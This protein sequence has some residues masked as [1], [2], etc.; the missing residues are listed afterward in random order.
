MAISTV[1]TTYIQAAPGQLY[2]AA[3]PTA[4]AGANLAAKIVTLFGL[5]YAAGDQR[6]TPLTNAW[7]SLNADGFKA[8]LKQEPVDY[9]PNDGAPF[10]V[11]FQHL[12]AT[13]E[14]LI[15]D[16]SADKLAEVLNV[17]TNA[18]ITTAATV[19]NA[20]RKTVAMGGEAYPIRYSAMYRYPSK[21]VPGEFDHVLIPFCTFQV[22][23]DYELSK[24]AVRG[25]KLMIRANP[26]AG[27]LVNPDTGRAISWIEDRVTAPHS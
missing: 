19:P 12:D 5:F 13:A 11:A 14:C 9:E 17:T 7:C 10:T 6:L 26:D 21:K 23:T 3:A 8:K 15:S 2:L 25:A 24:K 16:L 22:D 1:D 20:A 27:L 18:L 4:V